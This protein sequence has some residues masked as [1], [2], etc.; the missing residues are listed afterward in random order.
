MQI[1]ISII[2]ILFYS[3]IFWGIIKEYISKLQ[4]FIF[5]VVG[6]ALGYGVLYLVDLIKGNGD[7]FFKDPQISISVAIASLIILLFIGTLAG[8]IPANRAMSIKPIEAI[9]EE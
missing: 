9:R 2:G 5:S 6:F 7:Q 1:I 8:F 3:I 4:A